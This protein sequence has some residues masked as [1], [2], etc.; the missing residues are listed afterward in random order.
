LHF[1]EL[2]VPD[3]IQE[4][5]AWIREDICGCRLGTATLLIRRLRRTEDADSTFT[6][7]NEAYLRAQIIRRFGFIPDGIR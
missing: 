2:T 1:E 6:V 3:Y 4:A 5:L 7:N